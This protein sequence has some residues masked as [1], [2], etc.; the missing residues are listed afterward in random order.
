ME[1]HARNVLEQEN[2]KEQSEEKKAPVHGEN[3]H[4]NGESWIQNYNGKE[5]EVVNVVGNIVGDIKFPS[6]GP[7][8]LISLPLFHLL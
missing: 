7:L 4:E 3:Y 1:D 8:E 6:R 5:Q 2:F